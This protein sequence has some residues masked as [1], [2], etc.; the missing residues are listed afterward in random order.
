LNHASPNLGSDAPQTILGE[1]R[2][3]YDPIVID[4]PPVMP[5]ADEDGIR[6]QSPQGRSSRIIIHALSDIPCRRREDSYHRV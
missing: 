5:V 2:P 4:P 6:M 1:P 3:N